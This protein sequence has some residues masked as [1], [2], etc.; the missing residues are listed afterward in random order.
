MTYTYKCDKC[1]H[2]TRS[3]NNLL[4]KDKKKSLRTDVTKR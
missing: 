3:K 2:E 1:G 4:S